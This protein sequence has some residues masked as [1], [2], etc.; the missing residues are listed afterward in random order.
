MK[1]TYWDP[2]CK[3]RKPKCDRCQDEG[4][5]VTY[6]EGGYHPNR[7]WGYCKFCLAGWERRLWDFVEKF[8]ECRDHPDYIGKGKPKDCQWCER[9]YYRMPRKK[10]WIE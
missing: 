9:I 8:G 3:R 2:E 1:F 4:W 10:D 6:S 5:R 7:T